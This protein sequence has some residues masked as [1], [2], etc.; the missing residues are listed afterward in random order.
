M[1]ESLEY[2]LSAIAPETSL[3]IYHEDLSAVTRTT[4]CYGCNVD[5]PAAL[6]ERLVLHGNVDASIYSV[7]GVL[8]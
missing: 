5:R 6:T 2:S 4:L 1:K 8:F 7:I 3:Q